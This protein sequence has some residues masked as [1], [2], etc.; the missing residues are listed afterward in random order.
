M[1]FKLCTLNRIDCFI[2]KEKKKTP[3][4]DFGSDDGFDSEGGPTSKDDPIS[5]GEISKDSVFEGDPTSKDRASKS[6]MQ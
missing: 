1:E 2:Q 4:G 3:K 6:Y 5:E